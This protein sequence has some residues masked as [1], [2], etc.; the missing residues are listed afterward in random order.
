M[1]EKVRVL[2]FGTWGYGKAGLEALL[3]NDQ[4]QIIKIFTKWDPETN[5]PYLNQVFEAAKMTNIEV[6]NTSIEQMNKSEFENAVLN[7]GEIDI[8]LSCCYDRFFSDKILDYPKITSVNI[9][10][11]LL[12]KYR[13]VKPLENALVNNEKEIG[14]T[15]HLLSDAMDAGDIL[16]QKKDHID[17]TQTFAEL[18]DLQCSQ[19]GNIIHEFFECPDKYVDARKKQNESEKSFAPRLPFAIKDSDTVNE[20]IHKAKAYKII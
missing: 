9:H 1:R 20:I 5:N 6:I 17:P 15:L 12:P 18:Y 13:G 11:S 8:L 10:P 2:Y 19:I 16:V 3:R 14:V 7:S 4:V